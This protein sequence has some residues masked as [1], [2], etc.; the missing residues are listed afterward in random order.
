MTAFLFPGQ[1]SQIKGMGKELFTEY[2][3]LIAKADAILG[4]GVEELCLEDRKAQLGQTQF[5]Q[6]ALFIVNALSY[7]QKIQLEKCVPDY[8]AGH[9]L[10]EYNALFAA[11]V[12]DFATGVALVAKRGELMSQAASGGM[13]AV[14]G[15]TEEQ[16]LVVIEESGL[17]NIYLANINTPSQIVISGKKDEIDLAEPYFNDAGANYIPLNVSG[18]FHSILMDESKQNFRQ[19]IDDFTFS[20]PKIP[21]ISNLYARPYNSNNIKDTLANQITNPVKWTE[22]IRYL[23]G[24]DVKEFIQVGPGNVVSRLTNDIIKKTEP[25]IVDDVVEE[26]EEEETTNETATNLEGVNSSGAISAFSLGSEE[27]KKE[28]NLK[29]AYLAGAMYKGVSSK[30][31]VVKLGNAGLMGYLGTGGLDLNTIEE[32]IRFIQ[33]ELNNSQAYG[34][35]LL[36][37]PNNPEKV[38]RFVDL[39]LK[40][41][42]KK[43]EAS[44]YISATPSLVR[45]R[46][47]GLKKNQDGIFEVTNKVMGK[48]SRPEV[49][50]MFLSPAPEAI[51]NQLLAGN[52]ITAEQ[53][54]FAKTLPLADAICVEAD[55]GGHTDGGVAY[56]LL[57][58]IIKLRDEMGK[59]YQD[60]KKVYIGAAGGI[61]TPEA[62]AAAFI[63]GADFILTGSINQCS[64]ESGASDLV[65]DLL[66]QINVQ[67]TAY[68]PAGDMFELGARVQVLK[69]GLFFPSR[70]NKLYELYRL[71]NSLDEIDEKTRNQL[72]EKYFKRSFESIYEECKKF[73]ASDVIEK[74]EINSKHK[75]ALI[76]RWYFGYSTRLAM[77]GKKENK[78]DFQ[79]HCGPALGAF[80]Q[81]VRGTQ[82]E[83]WQQRHV[84]ELAVKLLNETAEILNQRFYEYG[85]KT[86]T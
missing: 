72:Q 21:V 81:W 46:L 5:T 1:G 63:L 53:A 50:Q 25:L 15:L 79:V 60:H 86:I 26:E 23:M 39:L 36:N 64:V 55:S 83:N 14:I 48:V 42:V 30:E 34:L 2:K 8:V 73:Y 3:D 27:F 12:F 35:N 70:A 51:I 29:Y 38:E 17:K 65:K 6:P 66:Q 44:A 84:D 80:N 57:P 41:G 49:A 40:Y 82:L 22:S 69:K 77:E 76:F 61:G 59:K 33:A 62:A 74:A 47:K 75:M 4:Y 19:F 24:K 32:A 85:Q 13:A 54:E 10:G 56:T 28:Y 9:S 67:D 68:A 78:V 45:F 43:I 31:M 18:A 58:A 20:S 11:G 16:T 52:K 37:N 71:Y 7:L